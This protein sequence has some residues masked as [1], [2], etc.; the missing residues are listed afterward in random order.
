MTVL[1]HIEDYGV[2]I[3]YVELWNEPDLPFFYSGTYE[4]FFEMYRAFAPAVKAAGFKVGGNGWA[5]ALKAEKWLGQFLVDCRDG[6]VPLD[7]YTFHRYDTKVAK[8]LQ[9][10]H[11]VRKAMDDTGF[12]DAECIIDEWGYDL[13]DAPYM[14]TVGGATFIASCLMQLPDAGI[15]AQTHVLLV[16]PI[17]DPNLGRFHGLTRRDGDPNPIFYAMREFEAF[18]ATPRRIRTADDERVLAGV[19]ESGKKLTILIANPSKKKPFNIA[20]QLTGT[21]SGTIR[22]FTQASFVAGDG[23]GPGREIQLG[24]DA[25]SVVVA[26]ETMTVIEAALA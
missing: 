23:F 14:G 1:R 24:A 21:A 19:D 22:E 7:F 8:V 10:C 9:R 20:L 4:E 26:P 11:E 17:S 16:D 18:Q 12:A 5:G 3:R 6:D 2:R 15:S 25:T 13:R